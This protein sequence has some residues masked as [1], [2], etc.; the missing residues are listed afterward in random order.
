MQQTGEATHAKISDVPWCPSRGF[1]LGCRKP[2]WV[3]GKSVKGKKFQGNLCADCTLPTTPCRLLRAESREFGSQGLMLSL[4]RR[5][6]MKRGCFCLCLCFST[7]NSIF[8]YHYTFFSQAKAILPVTVPGK[9]PCCLSP[10]VF[11][12]T[13]SR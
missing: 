13:C 2:T 8:H 12:L 6:S 7:F 1:T 10:P 11:S 3:Q 4:G 5:G 9:M